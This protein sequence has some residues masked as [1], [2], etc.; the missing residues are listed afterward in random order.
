MMGN[1]KLSAVFA[2]LLTALASIVT[3]PVL[4]YDV[5]QDT[6]GNRVYMLLLNDNPGAVYHSIN[7]ADSAP[8]FV[9]STSA[10]IIPA[11]VNGS[12][13]DLAALDFDVSP[14]ATLGATGDLVVTVSGL[15]AGAR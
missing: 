8:S 14:S 13:S 4:A 15:A 2:S 1:I 7:I 3:L 10:A 11:Q 9:T 5:E 6:T 12:G